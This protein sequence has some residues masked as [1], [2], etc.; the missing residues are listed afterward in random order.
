MAVI[1]LLTHS[2]LVRVIFLVT[3]NTI[4]F[5]DTKIL[6]FLMA[7]FTGNGVMLAFEL[8]FGAAMVKCFQIKLDD[9]HITTFV[10]SVT[11]MTFTLGNIV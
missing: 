2:T 9:I 11:G 5:S 4:I 6:G 10:I 8:E 1:A 7:T 3:V